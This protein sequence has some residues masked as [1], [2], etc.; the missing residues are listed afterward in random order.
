MRVPSHRQR[1]GTWRRGDALIFPAMLL[2]FVNGYDR[3]LPKLNGKKY[4]V[5][6]LC[7]GN[8]FKILQPPHIVL[9]YENFEN[10]KYFIGL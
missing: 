7:S 3:P 6:Y 2:Q 9:T 1:T 5:D 8:D 10:E 4:F